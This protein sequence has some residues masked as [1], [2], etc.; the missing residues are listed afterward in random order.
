MPNTTNT[1][2]DALVTSLFD[3]GAHR[4][5]SKTTRHPK[6]SQ[7]IF[8]NRNNF[9]IS[10]LTIPAK[11]LEKAV[12]FMKELG[13]AKKSV[14]WVGGK[15]AARK[16]IEEAGVRL[17]LP[18][19]TERWLGG[20]LTNYKILGARLSYWLDLER[21]VAEGGLEKYVKKERVVKLQ[22][23]RKLTRMFQGL[24]NFK[25]LPDAMVIIDTRE[26]YTATQ[27]AIKKRIPVVG[28]LSSDCDPALIAHPIP[29]NDDTVRVIE[30]VVRKLADAYEEGKNQ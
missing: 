17:G 7:Y 21:D 30:F 16:A 8:A 9:E 22:E 11:E 5:H 14:L 27:E 24:R 2:P 4:G 23:L 6:M 13:V 29:C 1:I 25:G 10:D 26:E 19:V 15:P 3:L 28:L 12:A 20:L 18:Y